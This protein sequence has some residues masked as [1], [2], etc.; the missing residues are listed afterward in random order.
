MKWRWLAVVLFSTLLPGCSLLMGH[1]SYAERQT[2]PPPGAMPDS[3]YKLTEECFYVLEITDID[4]KADRASGKVPLSQVRRL[5]K[6]GDGNELSNL[7]NY[8]RFEYG[9]QVKGGTAGLAKGQVAHFVRK[10][11]NNEL[12]FLT[13]DQ[14]CAK[15]EVMILQHANEYHYGKPPDIPA[16]YIQECPNLAH[17]LEKKN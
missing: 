15:N 11:D 5:A 13:P 16:E 14:M 12:I 4:E 2:C 17:V 9:F 6:Q 10:P 7:V 1:S 3:D 8:P